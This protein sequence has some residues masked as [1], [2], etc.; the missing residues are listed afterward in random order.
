MAQPYYQDAHISIYHGDCRDVLPA[1]TADAVVTDPPFKLSQSYAANV[2]ADNLDAVASVIDVARLLLSIVDAG[3]TAAVFY[4]N[5]IMPFA[6]D[7]FRRSG[8]Q[9]LRMLTL[10]RRWGNAHQLH[11]WMSTSDPVLVFAAPGRPPSYH[12]S[13]AHDVYVRSKPEPNGVV[14]PAQKP[15]DFVSQ[16]VGRLCP[17]HGTVLDPYMGSGTT[18]LAA[19][20]LGRK[21]IGVD[22]EERYCE[23]AARRIEDC[24]S[25]PT[26]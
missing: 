26:P 13:W 8:W 25:S 22:A 16:I 14:H 11:G 21:A 7:A 17:P 9:Y 19:R 12:G 24:S 6:L 23:M 3:T 20:S 15:V 10:Y 18:L 4:D 1:L 2:D 5:R